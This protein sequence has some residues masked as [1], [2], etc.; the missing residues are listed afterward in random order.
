[1]VPRAGDLGRPEG[2]SAS[3][4][5][6][7]TPLELG[8]EGLPLFRVH[9]APW[10]NTVP[11]GAHGVPG[12]ELGGADTSVSKVEALCSRIFGFSWGK[13]NYYNTVVVSVTIQVSKKSQ[14]D[15]PIQP[16]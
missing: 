14:G 2:P 15:T 5:D 16:G 7:A 4:V 6:V 11:A 8:G 1:M 13:R 10:F 9:F 12:T 3:S